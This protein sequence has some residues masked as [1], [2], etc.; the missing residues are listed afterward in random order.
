MGYIANAMNCSLNPL[1]YGK[2]CFWGSVVG[3][4]GSIP[5]FWLAGKNY[6]KFLK[7][8]RYQENF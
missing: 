7:E 6:S 3:Y 5:A 2:L 4:I 8:K 1:L